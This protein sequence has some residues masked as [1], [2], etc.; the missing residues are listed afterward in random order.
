MAKTIVSAGRLSGN[1]EV[2]T[3][4]TLSS[5]IAH[6]LKNYLAAIN[7]CAE[8]SE[9]K[10]R[11]IRGKIKAAGYLISNLQLQI[12]GVV[13]GKPS[14]EGFIPCSIIKNI[15]EAL[16]QYPFEAGERELVTLERSKDFEYRG[17]PALTNHIFYNLIKNSLHAIQ[18][19]DKGIIT[20]KLE[21]GVKFNK[22]IFK[23][24]AAGITKEFLPKIFELFESSKTAQG[25]MGVGLAFCKTIMTSYGGDIICN[26]V[27]GEYTE[28]VLS[29][30]LIQI[31]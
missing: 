20:I 19:A 2:Q 8:L 13:A 31:K 4:A 24:T 7:I 1:Q 28:F 6:E 21:T 30:P 11:D 27:E 9:G 16:E 26:S 5:S 25:G 12:K 18:N 14:K 22:V 17:N 23:D 15:N 3:I 29:F 10:L